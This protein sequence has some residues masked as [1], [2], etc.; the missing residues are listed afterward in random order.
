MDKFCTR[1]MLGYL[2]GN[3]PPKQ[4]YI[5]STLS[6]SIVGTLPVMED[7][8]YFNDYFILVQTKTNKVF[9]S[10]EHLIH[11]RPKI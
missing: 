1:K 2:K 10:N 7:T 5:L 6:G 11:I 3:Y 4:R 8:K 9:I